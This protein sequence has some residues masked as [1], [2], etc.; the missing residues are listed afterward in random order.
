M[1]EFML[2]QTQA[3]RVAPV[4]EAFMTRFPTVDA[5]ATASRADVLRAWGGLGYPRR[6]VALHGSAQ[7]VLREHG[8][9]VPDGLSSLRALPGVGEYTAAAVASLAYGVPV[10]AV[11]TNVRRIWARVVHGAEPDEVAPAR[12]REDAQSWLAPH[13]PASWNQ[14]MF[15]LGRTLCRPSPRCQ[16]CPMRRW[17]RFAAAGRTGR[18]SPR[19]QAPFE[20]SLRQVRG[21]VLAHLR[22]RSPVTVA[23]VTGSTGFAA[24]RVVDAIRGLVHDGVVHASPAA[25][26]GNPRARISLPL[27]LD[28][29][30]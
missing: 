7:V 17:C 16:E 8:G 19:R 20:G 3:S 10:A 6:A 27:D 1:S 9:V 23:T 21:A 12:L 29:A 25:L 5:L 14:A 2:Q 24:E 11:D 22:E 4:F 13:D 15:D 28:S 30:P 18:P 26:Q